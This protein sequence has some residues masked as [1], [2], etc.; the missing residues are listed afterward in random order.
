MDVNVHLLSTKLGIRHITVAFALLTV[1][2]LG[3]LGLWT[4]TVSRIKP[5]PHWCG[6][7]VG[8]LCFR[9]PLG[10]DLWDF[11]IGINSGQFGFGSIGQL[12]IVGNQKTWEPKDL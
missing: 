6:I 8:Q 7:M 3:T 2:K 12:E 4:R 10:D 11:G 9:S 5:A 1:P